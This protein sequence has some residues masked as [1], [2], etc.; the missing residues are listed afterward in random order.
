MKTELMAMALFTGLLGGCATTPHVVPID[1]GTPVAFVVVMSPPEGKTAVHNIAVVNDA[2]TG[3]MTGATAGALSGLLCGPAFFICSPF[4]A[5]IGAGAGGVA[6]AAAG[7]A[8][9]LPKDKAAQLDDRLRRLQQSVDPMLELRA[10]VL[11]KA[12]K[13]WELTDDTSGKVVILEV[14]SLYLTAEHNKN[15]KLVMQ[16][17]VS[18]RTG[19]S[20]TSAKT[21]TPQRFLVV[22]QGNSLAAWL[23]ERSDLPEAQLRTACQQ[24][25]TQV[26]SQ[27]AFN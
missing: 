17:L 2:G 1:Q 25:A 21:A 11:D 4:G 8:E 24:M 27:L 20:G 10:D 15:I 5:L 16:V 18:Q 12:G 13:H 6:G 9:S 22:T 7:A 3:A 14:Q 23:D 19:E 26:I